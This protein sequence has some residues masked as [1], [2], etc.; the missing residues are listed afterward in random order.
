[1]GAVSA[2]GHRWGSLNFTS[3]IIGIRPCTVWVLIGGDCF[4]GGVIQRNPDNIYNATTVGLNNYEIR[5]ANKRLCRNHTASRAQKTRGRA[6]A[7]DMSTNRRTL[8]FSVKFMDVS[9]SI[10]SALESRMGSRNGE[11]YA[12][13]GIAYPRAAPCRDGRG[14]PHRHC[15]RSVARKDHEYQGSRCR[16]GGSS[17]VL[18]PSFDTASILSHPDDVHVLRT[19]QC[20]YCSPLR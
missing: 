6:V 20:G 4:C 12:L 15:S 3:P 2:I 7:F 13:S 17:T 9:I 10:A 14:G 16:N 5:L 18:G 11:R 1:M 8:Q 19:P